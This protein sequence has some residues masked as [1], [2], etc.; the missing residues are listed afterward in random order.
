MPNLEA[1]RANQNTVFPYD[2]QGFPQAVMASRV[3]LAL[4]VGPPYA[5]CFDFADMPKSRCDK[6]FRP[7]R[8]IERILILHNLCVAYH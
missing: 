1:L 7:G 8:P 2:A 3:R 4:N 6:P 5:T